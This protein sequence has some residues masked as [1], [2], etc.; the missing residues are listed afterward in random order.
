MNFDDFR[1]GNLIV[2]D[3]RLKAAAALA[4]DAMVRYYDQDFDPDQQPEFSHRFEKKMK[5]LLWR[6]SHPY[7]YQFMYRTASIFPVIIIGAV[8]AWLVG[9][10]AK[11]GGRGP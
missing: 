5:W 6:I 9:I 11:H 4:H 3:E 2:T 7:L 10:S 8:I 1:G